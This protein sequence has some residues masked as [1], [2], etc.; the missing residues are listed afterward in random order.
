MFGTIGLGLFVLWLL[1]FWGGYTG[2]GIIYILL[3]AAIIFVPI[4]IIRG[5]KMMVVI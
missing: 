4:E 3:A 2:G 5:P 1:G